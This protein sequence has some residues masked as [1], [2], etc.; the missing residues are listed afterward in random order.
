MSYVQVFYILWIIEAGSSL[1]I[2]QDSIK[3]IMYCDTRTLYNGSFLHKLDTKNQT[4][5]DP[6]RSIIMVT[7]SSSLVGSMN[8]TKPQHHRNTVTP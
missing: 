5:E 8:T 7:T 6:P 1:I 3:N 4:S 2:E